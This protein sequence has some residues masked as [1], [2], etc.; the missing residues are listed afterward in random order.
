MVYFGYCNICVISGII[1][2]NDWII[3][4]L[5]GIK[6]EFGWYGIVFSEFMVIEWVYFI[7]EG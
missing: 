4:C 7:L 3:E 6:V 1:V 5:E 2:D